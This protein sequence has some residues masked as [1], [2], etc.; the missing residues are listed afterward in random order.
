MDG[1][2]RDGKELLRLLADVFRVFISYVRGQLLV[3]VCLIVVYAAGFALLEVPLW[4]LLA[5]VCGAFHLVPMFGAVLGL[6]I[7]VTAVLVAG[8]GLNRV[9]AVV[10]VFVFAQALEGFYLTPRIL[11]A[12]LRLSPLVV[13]LA[14]LAGGM[15]FGFLGML[16]AAP[17]AAIALLLWRVLHS[18]ASKGG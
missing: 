9:L 13:F 8:G 4:L 5:L 14:L 17:A 2:D 3:A 12:H 16:L 1:P 11:G 18:A 6:L 7:P 15:L 10:G